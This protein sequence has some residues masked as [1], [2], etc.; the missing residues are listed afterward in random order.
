MH[1]H[2]TFAYF[3]HGIL[4]AHDAGIMFNCI[5]VFT[6]QSI[7][8]KFSTMSEWKDLAKITSEIILLAVT[9]EVQSFLGLA[10]LSKHSRLQQ[11]L[12][13]QRRCIYMFDF[14]V[15]FCLYS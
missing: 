7:T 5:C 8:G 14:F 13:V 10:L 6:I 12:Q 9:D 11:T 2:Y 1:T 4:L 3:W 15:S